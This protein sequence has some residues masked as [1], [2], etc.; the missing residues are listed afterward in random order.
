MSKSRTLIPSLVIAFAAAAAGGFAAHDYIKP[1]TAVDT[2]KI[3]KAVM[4]AVVNISVTTAA[5]TPGGEKGN[6][7]GSGFIID[8]KNGYIVTNNHVVGNA[9][10]IIVQLPG[11]QQYV[12]KLIG[13]DK[14]ADI[15]VI[16]VKSDTVLPQ[17]S[18]ANS[19][20]V[21]LGDPVVAIGSPFGFH[22]SVSTGIISGLNRD[23]KDSP[24]QR[25]I[26]NDAAVNPGNSGGPLFN[27]DGK[28]IGVNNEIFSRSGASAGISFAIPSNL[29]KMV[30]GKLIADGK[31]HWG[32]MGIVMSMTKDGPKTSPIDPDEP[33]NVQITG[34]A[35]DSPA[36]KAGL[37]DGDIIISVNNK[38]V[39]D[40]SDVSYQVV[41]MLAGAKADIGYLRG[42][43]KGH[44][45]VTLGELPDTPNEAPSA[46]GP[47]NGNTPKF[48][49]GTPRP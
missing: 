27:R 11:E 47:D 49:F 28:V 33:Q 3:V 20:T 30:A 29:V 6:G 18:F 5:E 34:V 35:P 13:T 48:H 9:S 25:L 16:Q 41:P 37:K 22:H 17:Q 19:D 45:I 23:L 39:K 2:A 31:M 24:V 15:A 40:S 26:Q 42:K 10:K 36:E 14:W 43:E 46:P 1:E 12:A 44:A 21:N 38:A 4:P 7:T 8:G 32:Y